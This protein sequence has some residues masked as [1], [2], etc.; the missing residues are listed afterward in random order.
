MYA[1]SKIASWLIFEVVVLRRHV[2]FEGGVNQVVGVRI[3]NAM[4]VTRLDNQEIT[5]PDFDFLAVDGPFTGPGGKEKDL[6]TALVIVDLSLFTGADSYHLHQYAG[7][8][9]L[10][11]REQDFFAVPLLY[12]PGRVRLTNMY[13]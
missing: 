10:V 2:D 1:Q 5:G 12:S 7:N 3:V 8:A 11:T 4:A 13:H 6:R 9:Y